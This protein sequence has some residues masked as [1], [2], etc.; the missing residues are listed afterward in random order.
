MHHPIHHDAPLAIG[1]T[2]GKLPST[3]IF[4]IAGPLTLDNLFVFQNALR[5]GEL[6]KIAILDLSRVPYLDSAGMGAIVNYYVHAL[7]KGGKVIVVGVNSR[8][9][10]LFVLTKVHAIIPMAESVEEAEGRI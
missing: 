3:R 10:E 2:E 6:P 4:Q 7:N 8:A 9:M 1:S 5:S